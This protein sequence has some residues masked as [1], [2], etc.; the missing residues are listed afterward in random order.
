[1]S[2]HQPSG[3]PW[4][5]WVEQAEHDLAAA[6]D[7]CTGGW[8]DV[9]AVLSQQAAE[10]AAK[11]LWL[12]SRQDSVPRTHAVD[13]ILAKLGAPEHIVAAGRAL[14]RTYWAYRYPNSVNGPP[15]K[16]VREADARERVQDAQRVL[17]WVRAQSVMQ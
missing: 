6:E 12:A 7:N 4:R 9:A 2:G 10:K 15:F 13:D 11:A 3:V 1:M 8:W 16:L 14:A 17:E 5:D